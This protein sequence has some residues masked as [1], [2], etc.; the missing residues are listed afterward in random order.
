MSAAI[1]DDLRTKCVLA[2]PSS[3]RGLLQGARATHP[4]RRVYEGKE[5]IEKPENNQHLFNRSLYLGF[6]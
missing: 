4:G 2:K 6:D 1:C 5:R 3:G